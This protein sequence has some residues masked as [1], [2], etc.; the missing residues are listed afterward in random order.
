[1]HL[2]FINNGIFAIPDENNTRVLKINE[3][4]FKYCCP[5][6]YPTYLAC[7][8]F[9][10]AFLKY[11][12]NREKYAVLSFKLNHNEGWYFFKDD[13]SDKVLFDSNEL[14]IIKTYFLQEKQEQSWNKTLI[15]DAQIGEY[16]FKR[17]YSNGYF[18]IKVNIIYL[19]TGATDYIQFKQEKDILQIKNEISVFFKNNKYYIFN[20]Y[21][22]SQ[23]I[24]ELIETFTYQMTLVDYLI[25]DKIVSYS[26]KKDFIIKL[27]VDK[28]INLK[29]NKKKIKFMF[30]MKKYENIGSNRSDLLCFEKNIFIKEK[31]GFIRSQFFD[32]IK[33]R[34]EK[35]YNL[36]LDI[37]NKE[38]FENTL[39]VLK[40]LEI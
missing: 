29:T 18:N 15:F 39:L 30:M 12:A 4:T 5:D 24:K 9:K 10:L 3:N 6:I 16:R 37:S 7:Q 2:D 27:I 1:M 32:T 26:L 33:E 8:K 25:N 28:R 19:A 38:K 40:M 31:D 14:T 22:N 21:K 23:I 13:E 36:S 20:E 34:I 11:E 35:N 17:T